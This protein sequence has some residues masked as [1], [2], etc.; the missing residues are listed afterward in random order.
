MRGAW[1]LVKDMLNMRLDKIPVKRHQTGAD[2][3]HLIR[4]H[5][6]PDQAHSFSKCGG[7]SKGSVV[8]GFWIEPVVAQDEGSAAKAA[9]IREH[10][11]VIQRHLKC[12]HSAHRQPRYR[13]MIT[14]GDSAKSRVHQRNDDLR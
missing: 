7:I 11:Q 14:I 13:A 5:A 3:L 10:V 12:L 8:S 6:E 9:K 4:S 2:H 1:R